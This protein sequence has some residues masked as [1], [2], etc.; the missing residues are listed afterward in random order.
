MKRGKAVIAGLL[1]ASLLAGCSS[2]QAEPPTGQHAQHDHTSHQTLAPN[3]ADIQELTASISQ[4]PTFLDNLDPQIKEAYKI[5]AENREVLKWIPCYCGCA[6]SADHKSNYN[7]FIKEEH[8]D[9]SVVWDDHG[10]RC[11]TCMQIAVVSAQMKQEG[12]SIKEIRAFIDEAFKEGYAPPTP[13][14]M[15]Q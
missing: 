13:T 15:P 11:G 2:N 3:G 7:C 5:A 9:G 6:D 10:T 4:M 14:P 8:A 12:K 1:M